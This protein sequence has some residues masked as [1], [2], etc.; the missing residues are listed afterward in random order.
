MLWDVSNG[1]S[2]RSW[3]GGQNASFY[4]DYLMKHFPGLQV[5]QPQWAEE[6]ILDSLQ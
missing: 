4:A 2:R 6:A 1:V 5:T 3:A